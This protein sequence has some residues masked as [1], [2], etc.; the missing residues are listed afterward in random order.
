MLESLFGNITIEKIFFFIN[1]YGEGYPLGMAKTFDLPVNRI[2]QQLK[3]LEEGGIVVSRLAG[4]VRLYTFN[5]RYPFLNE[6]KALISKA[7]DFF[8]ENEK[9]K[10]YRQR[11]RP[12]RAGKPL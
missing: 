7:Y 8:P 1:T 6:L 4:R 11:T 12:R 2:Q 3:R 9:E 10:Y 5:P